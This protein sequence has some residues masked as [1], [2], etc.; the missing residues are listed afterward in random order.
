MIAVLNSFLLHNWSLD[1]V[2]KFSFNS[3]GFMN[4]YITDWK[5]CLYSKFYFR[6]MVKG[7]PEIN[8]QVDYTLKDVKV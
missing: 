8:Y 2:I 5:Y 1:C 6:K 4:T 3:S 7:T